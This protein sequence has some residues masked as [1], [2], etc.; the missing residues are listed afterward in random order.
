MF[1][2]GVE[3]NLKCNTVRLF[4]ETSDAWDEVARPSKD[5]C[6]EKKEIYMI[7]FP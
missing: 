7:D 6:L 5:K 2:K 4:R 3:Q 1:G